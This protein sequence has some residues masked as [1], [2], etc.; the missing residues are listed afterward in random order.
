VSKGPPPVPGGRSPEEREA[1]RREREARR[2]ARAGKAP[3]PP[4]TEPAAPNEPVPPTEPI[5]PTEP[6]PP[7]ESVPPKRTQ[8]PPARP[9]SKDGRGV[10]QMTAARARELLE[11]R[12]HAARRAR[13]RSTARRIL[14]AALAGVLVLVLGWFL[15]ALFQP[16]AGDGD[17]PVRVVVP[18]GAGV[19]DIAELLEKRGVVSSAFFFRAR[20]TVSGKS[21]ELKPG[22]YRLRRDMSYG[23]A[24]EVLSKGPA[25]NIVTLTIPEGRSRRE[26]SRIVGNSLRGDYLAAT[27][28]SRLLNPRRYGA[29]RP[30]DLEGFLFPATYELRRGRP[31]DALVGQ[32]LTAF[33]RA[34]A[35]VDLR[36]ARR[37]NLTPY[38]V[39]VIAS[40]VEREGAVPKERRLIAG[41]IYNRLSRGT[42]LGIDATIRFATGNWERPLRQSDLQSRSPYNTR[43][44]KGLPP[45]PIGN[46]GLAS[47]RAAT[48]PARTRFL[49]FVVKP[50]GRGEHDFSRTQA[51]HDRK[52]ER[53]FRARARRGGRSPS[54]P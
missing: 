27:R 47:I 39:L 6:V 18:S 46:P 19:A 53:Y 2:A 23:S 43:L 31:I 24:L 8:P 16:F 10:P 44:R 35:Q 54:S 50:G 17:D 20:A 15:L 29:R 12:Q 34:F 40:M 1:A 52:V 9:R 51:E 33:K 22:S 21:G 45:G 30:R 7:P 41:V 42:P 13:E 4:P 49:F 36:Y 25:P 37:K 48:R 3:P 11:K 32:Q 28:R 26:V 5:P 14:P 38:E